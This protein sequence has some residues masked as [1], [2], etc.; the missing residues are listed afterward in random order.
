[1]LE[2]IRRRAAELSGYG[3]QEADADAAQGA[4]AEGFEEAH[5]HAEGA[6]SGACRSSLPWPL[7]AGSSPLGCYGFGASRGPMGGCERRPKSPMLRPSTP[8][9]TRGGRIGRR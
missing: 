1:M 5:S 6:M 4:D 3:Y 8:T 7:G 2:D 9:G